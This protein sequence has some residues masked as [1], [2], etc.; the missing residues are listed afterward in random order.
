MR[1]S[2]PNAWR[3]TLQYMNRKMGSQWEIYMFIYFRNFACRRIIRLTTKLYL[4][5][6]TQI[7]ILN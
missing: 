6:R 4:V 7:V 2:S 3:A 1:R 5:Y